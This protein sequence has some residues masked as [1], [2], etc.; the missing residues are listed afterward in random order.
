MSTKK[1]KRIFKIIVI[2]SGI[3]LLFGAFAPFLIYL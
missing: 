1:Q 2:I 3:A